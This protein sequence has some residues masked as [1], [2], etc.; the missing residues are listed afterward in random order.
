MA[1]KIKIMIDKIIQERAGGNKTI[2]ETTRA[3][4]MLK[5]INVDKYTATSEDDPVVIEKIKAIA[6]DFNVK[7]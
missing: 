6:N 5:G 3:K 1:G 4:F 7:L 2:M